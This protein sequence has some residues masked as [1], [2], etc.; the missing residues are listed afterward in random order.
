M[1][2]V[3]VDGNGLT[4]E[5]VVLIARNPRA[6]AELSDSARERI[7]RSRQGVEAFLDSGERVYGITTGFGALK[8][9]FISPDH[10]RELQRNMIMSHSVGVGEPFAQEVVRAML[11]VRAN[12]LAK[13]YSGLRLSVVQALLDLLNR[14]VYPV[15]PCKGSV[16]SS[17]DLA[18]LSHLTLTLIGLG[19]AVYHGQR[20]DS[21]RALSL[22]GLEPVV[23]EAKEGLAL[24]NGT[25]AMTAVAALAVRD[26]ENLASTADVAGAMSLE[27]MRGVPAALDPRLHAARPYAGQIA[28][29]ANLRALIE[30]SELVSGGQASGE[31]PARVHDAYSLRCMPQVHGPVRD[32]IAYARQVVTTELNSATDNPLLFAEEGDGHVAP[33]SGG[34]FHGE[35]IALAMDFLGIAVAELGSISE[36]RIARLVDAYANE[37]SL[38]PFLTPSSGLHSGFMLAQYV[39]AA[40][41]SENK[42]LAHPAS[43]DSIP[44]SAGME[45]HVSMGTI[46]ARQA[47]EIVG[48]VMDVLSIELMA[49]AQG[50]DLRLLKQRAMP[51]RGTALAHQAVRRVV[52]F[53][54]TDEVMYPHVAAI[55]ELVAAGTFAD[56]LR[57]LP[58]Q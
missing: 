30:G 10:S 24:I 58:R 18:P 13:G 31:S 38:P 35:P 47:R 53:L 28:V 43:V 17:G 51:G 14:G 5:D 9:H 46:A 52:P 23:L 20:M 4:I 12:A 22:A 19:E 8:D 54:E 32:A 6:A 1:A 40:L 55:R 45:D 34:N 15:I 42:V 49:G 2:D 7:A 33:I 56:V 50:I 44:T 41:V 26:A 39:A 27:A 48:N 25:T 3:I 36:R 57:S 16:G 21:A 11:L 37:G 29:A